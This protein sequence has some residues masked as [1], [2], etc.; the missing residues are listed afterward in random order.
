MTRI[1]ICGITNLDDARAAVEAG[2]DA[3][4]FVFADSR[5]QVSAGQAREIV[6]A[7][8]PF[9]STVGVFVDAPQ[10]QVHRTLERAA[11]DLAQLHGNESPDYCRHLAGRVIKRFPVS[12]DD[13]PDSLRA[14]LAGYRVGAYLLDPGRGT[15]IA[16]RW[17]IARGIDLPLMIAGGLNPTNVADAVR[18]VRPYAVDVS[19]GIEATP[20]K[21][22]P[23]K[24][25]AFVQAVRDA[26]A[27]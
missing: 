8:P 27:S 2:A 19:S 5:R 16:F 14:R 22:D 17:E 26:D 6:A 15:G 13:T 23:D 21:K 25:R 11:L 24:M 9:V 18:I 7:L 4:G 20:G 10:E 3:L 12:D 1:K